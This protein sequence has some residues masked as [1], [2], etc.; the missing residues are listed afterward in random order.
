[1][2]GRGGAGSAHW[3]WVESYWESHR[4]EEIMRR[5]RATAPVMGSP[6][7][8][9]LFTGATGILGNCLPGLHVAAFRAVEVGMFMGAL[10]AIAWQAAARHGREAEHDRDFARL[11]WRWAHPGS[12]WDDAGG[13][14]RGQDGV[15][16]AVSAALLRAYRWKLAFGFLPLIGA[17]A[18]YAINGSLGVRFYRLARRFYETRAGQLPHP[19]IHTKR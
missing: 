9:R 8:V 2:T 6:S 1:M 11:L 14:P 5:T 7:R 19:N 18:G 4:S 16:T 3:R 13:E 10:Q 17:A 15:I 12:G